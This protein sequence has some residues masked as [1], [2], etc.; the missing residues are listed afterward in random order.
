VLFDGSTLRVHK[1]LSTPHAPEEAILQGVAELGIGLDGLQVVHGSTVA[2]NAALEG[3]GV[4]TALIT[5]HGFADLLTIGRQARADLYDLQPPPVPPPVPPELC[6]EAGGRLGADGSL[7]E[8]LDEAELD[9]LRIRPAPRVINPRNAFIMRTFL[10][11]VIRYGTGRRA[12]V[13]KRKDLAGKTGTTNDQRDTWFS[14]FNSKLVTT[15]WLGFD[16]QR[17]LGAKETGARAALPIWIDYMRVALDGVLEDKVGQPDGLV[18]ALIDSRTGEVTSADNPERMF[19]IFRVEY[20]PKPKP[21][22]TAPE[23][24]A[25]KPASRP[26]VLATSAPPLVVIGPAVNAPV[27]VI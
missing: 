27:V 26:C 21:V 1:V 8:P 18:T 5:N 23:S 20:A 7:L 17:P 10:S 19:E 22:S 25:T 14:G 9:E 12:L 16:S 11:D 4:P 6:L 3:K 15:T 13:L 24:N 2:T